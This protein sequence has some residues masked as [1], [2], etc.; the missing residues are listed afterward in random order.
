MNPS[1]EILEFEGVTIKDTH[2]ES[3]A[4]AVKSKNFLRHEKST[5]KHCAY[6]KNCIKKKKKTGNLNYRYK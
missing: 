1:E 6:M 3:F 2:H 5:W 4:T